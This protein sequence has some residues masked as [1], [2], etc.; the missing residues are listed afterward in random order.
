VRP[1]RASNI[2][3]VD[4]FLTMFVLTAFMLGPALL[5]INPVAEE[6]KI[7][8]EVQMIITAR[9]DDNSRTDIDLWVLGP[10]KVPVGY[11]NKDGR[12]ILLD[13]DDLGIQNDTLEVN[14]ERVVIRRNIENASI[15]KLIPGEYFVTIH[16]YNT[17][18]SM[19]QGVLVR[20]TEVVRV[21]VTTLTPYR[22]EFSQDFIVPYKKEVSVVSFL[23]NE[24]G[25][26][27]DIRTDLTFKIKG[28]TTL[29]P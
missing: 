26:L 8:P 27:T 21:T 18:A 4:F 29:G 22:V 5:W 19:E 10:N 1:R 15:T 9:W 12:Y 16:N 13:R 17:F 11:S 24:D 2:P 28:G 14:G 25:K 20:E 3:F 6:G 7:D 23:V